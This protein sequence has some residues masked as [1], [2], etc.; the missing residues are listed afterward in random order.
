MGKKYLIDTN[1]LIYYTCG[2]IP[3]NMTEKLD[4][5]LESSFYISIITKIEY[6]GWKKF[7]EE[8]FEIAVKF[9]EGANLLMLDDDIIDKTIHL[10]RSHSIKLPDAVIAATCLA[11]N[12]TLVSRNS[13]DF[14]LVSNLSLFNPFSGDILS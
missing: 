1:I 8:Q 2:F 4:E 11:N 12:F 13:V 14:K 3:Q 9:I 6:L 10:R 7:N 5:I